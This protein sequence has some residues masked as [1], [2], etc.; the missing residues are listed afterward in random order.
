MSL[1]YNITWLISTNSYSRAVFCFQEII[2][3][4]LPLAIDFFIQQSISSIIISAVMAI[5]AKHNNNMLY[6]Y[7]PIERFLL[8]KDFSSTTLLFNPNTAAKVPFCTNTLLKISTKN[9]NQI[10]L[11]YF[12]FCLD[13]VYGKSEIVLVGKNLYYKNIVLFIQHFQSFVP[14]R[15]ATLVKANIA[16]LLQ[17]SALE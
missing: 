10:H 12:N 14:F 6:L 8:L 5:Q 9:W 1:F 3:H 2:S 7:K 16:T 4:I 11:D 15:S 13:K 17:S